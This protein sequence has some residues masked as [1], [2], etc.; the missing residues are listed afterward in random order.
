[1]RSFGG[2]K[3]SDTASKRIGTFIEVIR[4]KKRKRR[5]IDLSRFR[6]IGIFN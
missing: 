3:G 6:D 2:N 5:L 4:T 1:M